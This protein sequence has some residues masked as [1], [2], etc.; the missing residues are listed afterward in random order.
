MSSNG[1]G[2]AGLLGGMLALAFEWAVSRGD[3]GVTFAPLALADRVIRL[4]PG[5][6]ANF[7]I[8]NLGKAASQSLAVA[9][10]LAFVALGAVLP[11]RTGSRGRYRPVVAGAVYALLLC[12]ASVVAPVRPSVLSSA[13]AAAVAGVLVAAAAST[14]RG[15]VLQSTSTRQLEDARRRPANGL[16]LP[17]TRAAVA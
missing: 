2:M 12:G 15:R 17:S 3:L 1:P 16:P 7:A 13:A 11:A 8:E 5:E 14:G 4:A 10:T 6:A 9:I